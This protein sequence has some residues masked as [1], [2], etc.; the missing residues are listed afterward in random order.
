MKFPNFFMNKSFSARTLVLLA[1]LFLMSTAASAQLVST[2]NA[3]GD[4]DQCRNGS[5][6][7]LPCA[8][9]NWVNGNA[10]SSNSQ[11]A[12]DQYIPYRMKFTGLTPGST[13]IVVI[14][15]DTL[16]G[17]H[18][19]EDYL[20][21][22]NTKQILPRSTSTV[23]PRPGVDICSDAGGCGAA[24]S[25][26]IPTDPNVTGSINP[27]TSLPIYQPANQALTM[28]GGTISGFQYGALIVGSQ[29]TQ[30][31]FAVVF[32]ANRA[33][34][35]LGWSGH[36][37]YAGDW[38]IGNAAGNI[39]GSPYHISNVGLCADPAGTFPVCTAGGG[40]NRSLSAD[41]V[42]VAGILQVI[43]VAN[44]RD[45]TGASSTPFPF[46]V[47][48]IP[49]GGN[50]TI[51]DNIA[52]PQGVAL[53]AP[54]VLAFGAGNEVTVNEENT[55]GWSLGD[56]TCTN[57][58]FASATVNVPTQPSAHAG[59]AIATFSQG[60]FVSCTFTNFQLAPTAAPASITGQVLTRDG[61]PMG[62]ISVSLVDVNTGEV[63]LTSTNTAGN[64][65]FTGLTVEHFYR[66]TLSGK[67]VT[68]QDPVRDFVLHDDLTNLNF[69]C[70]SQ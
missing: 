58:G 59:T 44:P 22:Y 47:T 19:A 54:G 14:G 3:S 48:S 7:S 53:V 33:D 6:G 32:T 2:A 56:L 51:T 68:F 45:G 8:G 11:Y 15:Y 67:R 57:N 46:T 5:D 38:G 35:V 4:V 52:G 30:Q 61:L 17:T 70:T 25:F 28:F 42:T 63:K 13:Y 36:I 40:P 34:P 12:E 21:T 55:A 49:G 10:G 27:L 60:G 26:T 9:S 1:G 65:T 24:S 69:Y 64:Y 29:Q 18:H 16:N 62:R 20:G 50:V 39:S 66:L 37:A 41:A 43:K 31:N 23:V